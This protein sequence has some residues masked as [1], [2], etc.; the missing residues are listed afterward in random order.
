MVYYLEMDDHNG[1][2]DNLPDN[3]VV[4]PTVIR[5]KPH[6]GIPCDPKYWFS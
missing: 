3:L 4:Q 2:H 5:L 6:R 1:H